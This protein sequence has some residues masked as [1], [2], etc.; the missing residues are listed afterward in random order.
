MANK[1]SENPRREFIKQAIGA[2]VG[3][4]ALPIASGGAAVAAE[5]SAK[6]KVCLVRC[7]A[8]LKPGDDAL[9]VI[10]KMLDEGI[11]Y[12]SGGAPDKFWKATFRAQDKVGVKVNT[13][14]E[15]AINFG[16]QITEAI[17]GRLAAAGVKAENVLVWDGNTNN[18]KKAGYKINK[19]GAGT[20][21]YGTNEV[22]FC[23]WEFESGE[24]KARFSKIIE[25][26]TA[27][28]NVPILKTHALAGVSIALKNHYGSFDTPSKYHASSCN[29]FIGNLNQRDEIKN[30]QRLVVCD[31][32]RVLYA[33]GPQMEMNYVSN[34]NGLIIGVDPVAVDA[35]GY[36]MI[37]R[38][39]KGFPTRQPAILK[40]TH[41]A[42]ASKLGLGKS[43]REDIDFKEITI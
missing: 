21:C 13:V 27:L 38:I 41:I 24:M 19:D 15:R 14:T 42:T 28:I 31:A 10:K 17:S 6:S 36:E 33:G 37:K 20:R 25:S 43:E 29:P 9:P 35:V 11:K 22:G 12:I 4:A 7:S 16:P 32:M 23:D 30:R 2:A 5:K 3:M 40:P 8:D 34:F 18:L 39:R 26:S 1:N